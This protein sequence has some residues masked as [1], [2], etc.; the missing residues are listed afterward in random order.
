MQ[1]LSP[2]FFTQNLIL[3]WLNN[4]KL[5]L[6]YNFCPFYPIY[7]FPN[8]VKTIMP[9]TVYFKK[10]LWMHKDELISHHYII[11]LCLLPI[12]YEAKIKVMIFFLS[13]PSPLF[14]SFCSMGQIWIFR[15]LIFFSYVQHHI[16]ECASSC[17]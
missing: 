10:L 13:L 14:F 15:H 6:F 5:N 3:S 9:L 7:S 2:C 4:Y 12:T 11:I 17:S 1:F 8:L 16:C